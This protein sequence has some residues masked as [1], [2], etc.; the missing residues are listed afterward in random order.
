MYWAG[1]GFQVWCQLL[2]HISRVA[3]DSLLIIDEPEVY[4][5]PDVQRQLLGI[6]RDTGPDILIATHSTEIMGEADPSEIVLIDKSKRAGERLQDVDSVQAAMDMIGS[7]QNITLTQLARNRKLLFVEGIEDFKRI[8]RFARQLGFIEL[9]SGTGLTPI[10][11]EGFSSW[12]RLPAFVWGIEKTFKSALQIG[13]IFD[14]DYWCEEE[15]QAVRSKLAKNLQLAHIHGRKE[16]ENYL[17]VPD[18][19]ERA[20]KKAIADRVKRSN[21]NI[22]LSESIEKILTRITKPLKN[23]AQAQYIKRPLPRSSAEPSSLISSGSFW[24]SL[25]LSQRHA[26]SSST[27]GRTRCCPSLSTPRSLR[28]CS[29]SAGERSLLQYGWRSARTTC[30]TCRFIRNRSRSIRIRHCT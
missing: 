30:S 2:T 10:E 11:S 3:E 23:A 12:E 16:M 27:I 19:L 7:V 22:S 14:R 5:H 18:V 17:L 28:S 15:I 20:I 9:S 25:V 6:L 4:L 8:R 26:N 1:F 29:G 24:Q 21:E 13:A